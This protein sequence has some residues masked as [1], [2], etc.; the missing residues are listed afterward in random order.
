[1]MKK[2]KE[3]IKLTGNTIKSK[4][5]QT[6]VVELLDEGLKYLL[7]GDGLSFVELYY[8]YVEKIYNK[9]IP[10]AKIANKSRVKQS[11]DDYKEKAADEPYYFQAA[12]ELQGIIYG[13]RK[14][15][16]IMKER[17]EYKFLSQYKFIND[18]LQLVDAEGNLVDRSGK[19]LPKDEPDVNNK[20]EDLS[21]VGEFL[22]D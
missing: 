7:N 11:V 16:D 21:S 2:G 19:P 15:E 8:N 22:D 1:M 3:K 10:L 5:L 20:V 14:P 4:K 18:K 17:I 13:F 6:Y 12:T 9:E